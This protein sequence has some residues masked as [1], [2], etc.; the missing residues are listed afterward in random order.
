MTILFAGGEDLDFQYLGQGAPVFA[1][2]GIRLDATAGR[3]RA[4]YGRYA[5]TFDQNS[6]NN[7]WPINSVYARATFGNVSQVWF[8]AR[9]VMAAGGSIGPIGLRFRGPGMVERIRITNTHANSAVAG[10][11]N[12]STVNA[13]GTVTSLGNTSAGF[14]QTPTVPDK[15]DIFI[16]YAVAGSMQIYINGTRVFDFSG[17]VTTDGATQLQLADFGAFTYVTGFSGSG[18]FTAWSEVIAATTDTRSLG[19]VTQVPTANGN[20][21]NWDSGTASDIGATSYATGDAAPNY[22]LTAGLIQEYQVTP[23]LPGGFYSILAVV[24][25]ARLA[26]SPSPPADMQFMVRSAG[27]DFVSGTLAPNLSYTTLQNVWDVNPA[28][29]AA[30]LPTDL[31]SASTAYNMGLKSIT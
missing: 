19:L 1:D 2:A 26:A 27:A 16:N 31:P 3:F 7:G 9:V 14:T 30:W 18:S 25:K 21:H 29:S 13:A 24:H 20:T 11:Y 10:P 12:V 6:Q 17:D 22:A 4:G 15:L 8:S 5:I 28:T 23:A